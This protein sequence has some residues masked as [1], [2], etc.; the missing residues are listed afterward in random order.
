MNITALSP[1]AHAMQLS[2]MPEAT[3]G[4]GPDRDG[5]ADNKNVGAAANSGASASVPKGMGAMVDTRA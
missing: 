5:D 3:E 4:S 2:R 1:P